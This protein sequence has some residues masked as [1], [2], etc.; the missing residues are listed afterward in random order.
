MAKP[1]L[2]MKGKD[3]QNASI[4]WNAMVK[5]PRT[6]EPD[7]MVSIR[8]PRPLIDASKS[9]AIKR[10]IPYSVLIREALVK[11]LRDGS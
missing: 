11:L 8:M 4:D 9:E 1:A 6:T 2:C 5:A 3:M 7:I 10:G